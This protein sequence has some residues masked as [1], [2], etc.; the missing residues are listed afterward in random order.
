MSEDRLPET[1]AVYN[2][3]GAKYAD[4]IAKA[5]LPQLQEF[6]GM[7]IPGGRVLD[8]GCCAG[9]DSAILQSAGFQVLGIDIS[10]VFIELAKERVS[11]AEFYV[12]DAR[13]LD[14]GV[15]A[16]DGVWMHAMLLNLDREEI[17]GVLHNAWL[18]MKTGAVIGVGVK[19]GDGERFVGEA[20]V[21]NMKRRETYFR[22]EELE[23]VFQKQ[24]FMIIKSSIS[25]DS[26]NR[27]TTKW[28][29]V[30]AKK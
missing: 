20:L 16:F 15:D 21:E 12:G 4:Q 1:I 9:R 23:G 2:S 5:N 18:A 6:I 24:G 11:G 29:Y 8:V 27:A 30:F 3:L 25:G 17:P 28:V 19:E 22:L 13:N 10:P 26:L 14:V 7:L